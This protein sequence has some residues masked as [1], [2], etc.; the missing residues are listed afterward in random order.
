MAYRNVD[1]GEHPPMASLVDPGED[2][3]FRVRDGVAE[4]IEVTEEWICEQGNAYW[5]P[6]SEWEAGSGRWDQWGHRHTLC[7]YR[8]LI[9]NEHSARRPMRE[10][11]EPTTD[12]ET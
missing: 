11:P 10:T 3:Y 7:G 2:A 12:G 4:R 1:L 8:L 5:G 9:E 6:C